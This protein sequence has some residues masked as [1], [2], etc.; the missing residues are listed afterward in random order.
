MIHFL[1]NRGYPSE[2]LLAIDLVPNDGANVYAAEQFIGPAVERLTSTAR[3]A[4]DKHGLLPGSEKVD[5]VAHS[6]GAFSSRWYVAKIAPRR[7]RTWVV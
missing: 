5:I 6:M 1:V 2:Y 3:T 4:R 7:V